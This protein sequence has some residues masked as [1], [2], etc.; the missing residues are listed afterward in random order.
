DRRG[1]G[2][3]SQEAGEAALVETHGGQVHP[4]LEELS[5]RGAGGTA[6]V[7]ERPGHTDGRAV[8]DREGGTCGGGD[9]YRHAGGV[10]PHPLV[11]RGGRDGAALGESGAD[12]EVAGGMHAAKRPASGSNRGDGVLEEPEAGG[13]GAAVVEA[14]HAG[15]EEHVPERG[16]GR[17]GVQ[18]GVGEDIH[19]VVF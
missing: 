11:D 1:G 16:T 15:V 12:E 14:V 3:V 7:R 9:L 18:V 6:L 2:G 5:S 13:G 19:D 17:V 10:I 8:D 4:H